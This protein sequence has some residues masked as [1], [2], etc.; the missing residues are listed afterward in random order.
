MEQKLLDDIRKM[1]RSHKW[2]RLLLAVSGGLD[3]ICLAHY[4]IQNKEALGT[5]W[6]G[7]VHVHHGLRE[8]TADAD[9]EFVQK[10]AEANGVPFF[11]RKLDGA[12]LKAGGSVEENA[13]DARYEALAE[14]ACESC[15]EAIV[16][17]HHAGDQAETL[18]LRLRRGVTL[19]GLSGMASARLLTTIMLYRPLLN[20]TR[21]RLKEYARE[22]SLCWREDESNADIKFARNL[23]RHKLLPN[24]EQ[25]SP[26]A[27]AQL[28][29]IA[30]LARTAYKNVLTSVNTLCN[31]AI[32]PEAE[33]PFEAS[34]APYQKVLA[35]SWDRVASLLANPLKKEEPAENSSVEKGRLELFRLWLDSRGFRFP[36]EALAMTQAPRPL[37]RFH[38]RALEKCRHIL[39]IYDVALPKAST[40]LYLEGDK[41]RFSQVEGCWRHPEEGDVLWPLDEKIKQRPLKQ[42]LQ[43]KGIPHWVRPSLNVFAQGHRVVFVSGVRAGKVTV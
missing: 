1:V 39:W 32:I 43:E 9:A 4:F 36:V 38:T 26:G 6:L 21:E 37:M 31:T 18:Y 20:V 22:N 14:I 42:W 7:I 16:T 3:S 12:V 13:R 2:K 19:A 17:A 29:R 10:F 27:T 11:L 41:S 35:L 34:V 24:L 40:N 33:W 15:A 8:R 28:C 5:E 23:V 30:G 25:F